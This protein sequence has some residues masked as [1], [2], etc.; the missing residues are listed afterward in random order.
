MGD[1]R[2]NWHV[3]QAPVLQPDAPTAAVIMVTV[4]HHPGHGHPDGQHPVQH[5][6]SQPRTDCE[7]SVEGQAHLAQPRGLPRLVG[8]LPPSI[9]RPD[10]E[11]RLLAGP[12]ASPDTGQTRGYIREDVT[13]PVPGRDAMDAKPIATGLGPYDANA[14]ADRGPTFSAGVRQPPVTPVHPPATSTDLASATVPTHRLP[15]QSTF[16]A[17]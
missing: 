2:R 11:Y 8:R 9:E 1:A 17:R 15:R 5:A 16:P 4:H 3:E 6:P 12:F 14:P 13:S 10:K 7:G